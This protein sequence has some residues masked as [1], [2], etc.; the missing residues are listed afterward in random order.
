[1]VTRWFLTLQVWC[2]LK[3]E[4][5]DKLVA[6]SLDKSMSTPSQFIDY[7]FEVDRWGICAENFAA[8]DC[9]RTCIR[10]SK[11]KLARACWLIVQANSLYKFQATSPPDWLCCLLFTIYMQINTSLLRS[12]YLLGALNS[13][14]HRHSILFSQIFVFVFAY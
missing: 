6:F 10:K 4:N 12:I 3:W 5:M 13:K 2:F 11:C 1:M 14:I 9:M 8:S 7:I